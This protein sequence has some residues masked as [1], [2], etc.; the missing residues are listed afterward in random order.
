M[1]VWLLLLILDLY[2]VRLSCVVMS[3]MSSCIRYSRYQWVRTA[4]RFWRKGLKYCH[5]VVNRPAEIYCGLF[6]QYIS[7]AQTETK[8]KHQWV[9]LEDS[10]GFVLFDC[11]YISHLYVTWAVVKGTWMLW[12]VCI[13]WPWRWSAVSKTCLRVIHWPYIFRLYLRL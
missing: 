3:Y 8:R 7:L 10:R 9:N 1:F 11:L 2:P 12:H 5:G 4:A 6:Y 13:T